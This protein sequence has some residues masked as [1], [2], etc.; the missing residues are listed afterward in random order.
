MKYG[1]DEPSCSKKNILQRTLAEGVRATAAASHGNSDELLIRPAMVA[2]KR[3]DTT[4]HEPRSATLVH[5]HRRRH[6]T[7]T[8]AATAPYQR[9]LCC[10]V[11]R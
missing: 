6:T 3:I 9:R 10:Q 11:R 5:V 4:V 2:L 8:I 1:G 7:A